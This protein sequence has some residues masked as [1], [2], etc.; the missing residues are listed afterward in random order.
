MES[1]VITSYN[2]LK[3]HSNTVLYVGFDV[4]IKRALDRKP[5]H[6]N[7][8]CIKLEIG[9]FHK[10]FTLTGSSGVILNF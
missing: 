5:K 8:N 4:A 2:T 10:L 6:N 1:I 7:S 3:F 9:N